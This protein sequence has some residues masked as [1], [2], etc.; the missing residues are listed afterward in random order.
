G[1]TYAVIN[2]MGDGLFLFLPIFIGYTAMK[3]F[4]GSPFLGMMIAS[5]LVYTDFI[6]GVVNTKFV[7]AG[8]LNFF[9]L[10]FSVP[11]AGYG[12]TVMPI[13]AS[14]AFCAFLEKQLRKIIPDVVKLFL[15]PF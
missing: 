12:S 1:S 14:T 3:K 4:G 7:E 2:A 9:G 15:V 8:G 10:P 6:N 5:S 11:E 13:I